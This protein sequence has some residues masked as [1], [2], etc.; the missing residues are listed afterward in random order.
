MESIV[1]QI[2]FRHYFLVAKELMPEMESLHVVN[3][4]GKQLWSS[5]PANDQLLKA[6]QYSVKLYFARQ[7]IPNIFKTKINNGTTLITGMLTNAGDEAIGSLVVVF[8]KEINISSFREKAKLLTATLNRETQLVAELESMTIELEERYEELNLVYDSEDNSVDTDSGPEVL[9]ELVKNCTEYLDVAMTALIMPREDLALFSV[10]KNAKI[11]YV[12]SL[13]VQLKNYSFPW[14]EKHCKS[15]VSNDL[16]DVYRQ[17]IFPDIPYKIVCSPVLVAENTLGGI[18]VT[19]NPSHAS[20]FTNSDRNLLET[21]A[22][23]SAK[24]AMAN[25]DSLTGLFK[26]NAFESFLEKA[27]KKSHAE[28]KSYCVLQID[29]DGIRVVND[30]ISTKAGD[31]ILVETANLIKEKVRETDVVSRLN[32]D[33][34]GVLL[35]ACSLETGCAIADNIRIAIQDKNYSFDG[36]LLEITACVGVASLNAD[37]ENIES[38]IAASELA[39]NIAKEQGRNMVQVYQQADTVLQ[40]RKGEVHWIREIQKA[41]NKDRF[42]L[43][44]QPIIPINNGRNPVH[45]EILIRMLDENENIISPNEFIPAAERYRI[46]SAI[47]EW[48]VKNAFELIGQSSGISDYL[49]TMNLS[50]LSIQKPKFA[51]RIKELAD[52]SHIHSESI[53]FE[54]TET[55]AINN[56]EDARNFIIKLSEQGFGIALDDFGTGSSTF[57][58]LKQL[59]IDYLKID[60]SFIKDIVQDPFVEE[61]VRAIVKVSNVREIQTIAEFVEN[62]EILQMLNGMGVDYA[63]GYVFGKPSPL[64]DTISQLQAGTF[65]FLSYKVSA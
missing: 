14:I 12:H 13:L 38:V 3:K 55:F 18:I 34:Y 58:Y 44:C 61:I 48:V 45:F 27:L 40:R 46:I 15:I 8:G 28:A 52:N 62:E 57:S 26:R 59:P 6:M 53:C 2:D 63:Q 7:D 32:A 17:E 56:L 22:K 4:T 54:V 43:F 29:L 42:Q 5:S 25:Y 9:E 11:H 36:Q 16:T 60:G 37:S 39:T 41:L 10:N 19:L 33:K 64:S 1:A 50:G 47:D 24:I 49:W 51:E 21:M 65:D 35:D 20:D 30:A 23:K 31:Q